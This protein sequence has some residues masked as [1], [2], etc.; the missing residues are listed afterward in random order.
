STQRLIGVGD[1]YDALVEQLPKRVS[2]IVTGNQLDEK[3]QMGPM[4]RESDAKRVEQ[5]VGEAVASG[6]RVL[7][8]GRREGSIFQPTLVADVKP[9]MRISCDEVFGPAVAVTRASN[10]D[11]AIA[12]ANDTRYGLSA[13][14]FTRSL[15]AAMQFA[16]HVESGNLHVNWGPAWRADLMPYGGLKE[17]GFG[18]EGPK[19]AIHEMTETKAVVIHGL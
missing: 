19:Y 1:A 6:A 5:W 12:M 17:S 18:K 2:S 15:D 4:I 13:G 16:R 10:V 8:G 9:T 11:Q 14:L 3:T 7:A